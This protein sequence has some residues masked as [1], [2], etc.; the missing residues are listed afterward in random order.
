[1]LI[2]AMAASEYLTRRNKYSYP[3][4]G[5]TGKLDSLQPVDFPSTH[6]MDDYHNELL[7]SNENDRTVLGYL[8][9]IFWGHYLGKDQR[10]KPERA[11]GKVRLALSGRDRVKGC[12]LERMR[13][14]K[15]LGIDSVAGQIRAAYA[16]LKDEHYSEALKLLCRIPQLGLAFASKVC[17]FL[18]PAKCGVIDSVIARNYPQFGFLLNNRDFLEKTLSHIE[19]YRSYCYFLQEQAQVLNSLGQEHLWEDLDGGRYS[20]RAVDVERGLYSG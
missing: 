10:G 7:T 8:S 17:A 13:G 19:N 20:W 3:A 11:L 4:V 1:M 9:T 5:L 6:E 12:R 15:D 18:V 14:V 16:Q 2:T